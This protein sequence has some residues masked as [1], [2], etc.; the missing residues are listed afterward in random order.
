MTL[1]QW[2]DLMKSVLAGGVS[3]ALIYA[4]YRLAIRVMDKL[5]E[6]ADR[7][8]AKFLVVS[9]RQAEALTLLAKT[10]NESQGEQREVLLAMRVLAAKMDDVKGWMRDIDC[11]LGQ[12]KFDAE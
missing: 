9:D 5:T 6:L 10:V 1:L 4:G 3:G 11:R 8:A 2:I 12:R 7:W